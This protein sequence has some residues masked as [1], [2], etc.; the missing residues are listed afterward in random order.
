MKNF[1]YSIPGTYSKIAYQW[2][3]AMTMP[4]PAGVKAAFSC[5]RPVT[6]ITPGTEFTS[7]TGTGFFVARDGYVYFITASHVLKGFDRDNLHI[8]MNSDDQQAAARIHLTQYTSIDPDDTDHADVTCIWIRP[9]ASL[10]GF[11]GEL[12]FFLEDENII[13]NFTPGMNL[14][15]RGLC[16]ELS[17]HEYGENS[18]FRISFLSGRGEYVGKSERKDMHL[19][20]VPGHVSFPS[21]DGLSGAPVIWIEDEKDPSTAAKFAGMLLRGTQSSGIIHFL[22]SEQIVEMIDHEFFKIEM[23]RGRELLG[24]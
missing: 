13:A 14:Y 19:M 23:A 6:F 7:Y 11:K 5:V 1:D 8:A 9:L 3:E 18:K 10:S 16:P 4:T 20:R 2:P 24:D 12:P 22:S 21:F 15:F 17:I